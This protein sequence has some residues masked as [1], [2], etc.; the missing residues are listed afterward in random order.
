MLVPINRLE[1]NIS[2]VFGINK[3]VYLTF[4]RDVDDLCL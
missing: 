2:R 1:I 4:K 3:F